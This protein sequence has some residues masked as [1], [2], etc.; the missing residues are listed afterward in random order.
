MKSI[1]NQLDMFF[2]KLDMFSRYKKKILFIVFWT[3]LSVSFLFSAFIIVLKANGYQFNYKQWKVIQT[4]MIILDGTP[5]GAKINVN[6][7]LN[8]R[9]L[10]T[11]L[12][13]L[14][15]GSYEISVFTEGYQNWQRIIRVDEGKAVSFQNIVLFFSNP[16]ECR[17]P[18]SNL[19]I[20]QLKQAMTQ[21]NPD[22]KILGNEIFYQEKLVT[23]FSSDVLAASIYPDNQHLVFQIDNQIRV[24]ELDGSNNTL[25]L[26]LKTTNPSAFIFANNDKTIVYLDQD[27][28]YAKNIR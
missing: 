5:H 23:R 3:V 7:R 27:Q 13:A 2:Y 22:L 20:D 12:Q 25:L 4:G 15:P 28:I 6:G 19:T 14:A 11:R 10:P 26:N 1:L 17:V 24:I 18:N 8:G 9:Q 21:N 16:E